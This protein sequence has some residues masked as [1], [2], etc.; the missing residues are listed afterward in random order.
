MQIFGERYEDIP[1]DFI[2]INRL[3]VFERTE[4]ENYE[5]FRKTVIVLLSWEVL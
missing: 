2:K 1:F 5:L 4:G 3:V